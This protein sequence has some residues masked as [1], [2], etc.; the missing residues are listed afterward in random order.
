MT[1][2]VSGSVLTTADSSAFMLSLMGGAW[3]RKGCG[4]VRV[5]LRLTAVC[6]G[7]VIST[8]DCKTVAAAVAMMGRMAVPSIVE[9]FLEGAITTP[10]RWR[11]QSFM[12]DANTVCRAWYHTGADCL[13]CSSRVVLPQQEMMSIGLSS[14][15]I[16][17]ADDGKDTALRSS[18]VGQAV[19]PHKCVCGQ[20]ALVFAKSSGESIRFRVERES[21]G[22]RRTESFSTAAVAPPAR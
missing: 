14:S 4:A 21:K 17:I 16:Q 13:P 15:N 1:C 18:R 12:A 19:L 11:T 5:R 3:S 20:K 2:R 22:H 7:M 10:R 9:R 8:T 6:L